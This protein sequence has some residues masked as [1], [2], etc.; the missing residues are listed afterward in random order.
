MDTGAREPTAVEHA[1]GGE[2][3]EQC[4]ARCQSQ[5]LGLI[6][7]MVGNHEDARDALQDTFVKCWRHRERVAELDN[8]QAW[9]FRVAMNTARDLRQT[10]WRRHRQ[11]WSEAQTD[12]PSSEVAVEIRLEYRE[13]LLRV[14]QAIQELRIEE[15]EVFLLRQNGE[16]T[17]E[18]I[19]ATLD[20]PTGTAKTRMRQ[21]LQHLRRLL[22]ART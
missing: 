12:V 18:Q 19:A 20:I 11:P 16:L 5:L 17:Y 9:V 13:Q 21:A 4:F 15:R 6:Y 7:H 8:L 2:A 10:A 22:T 3:L 14:R 1:S